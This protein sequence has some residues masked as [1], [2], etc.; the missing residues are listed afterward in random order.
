MPMRKIPQQECGCLHNLDI[1][2]E[3]AQY[4]MSQDPSRNMSMFCAST[5]ILCLLHPF[6]HCEPPIASTRRKKIPYRAG[7]VKNVQR[8]QIRPCTDILLVRLKE[9][10]Q[11]EF[12]LGRSQGDKQLGEGNLPYCP[13]AQSA[14]IVKTSRDARPCRSNDRV[15]YEQGLLKNPAQSP[16]SQ[17]SLGNLE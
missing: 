2:S 3:A 10:R 5:L 8:N 13:A 7:E 6:K 16:N 11:R 14:H 15:G 9:V 4:Y 12:P 1:P 17:R